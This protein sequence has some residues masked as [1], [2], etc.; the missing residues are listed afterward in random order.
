MLS[1]AT[2]S[3]DL[4]AA[5]VH[6]SGFFHTLIYLVDDKCCGRND[7]LRWVLHVQNGGLTILKHC[8]RAARDDLA[9]GP[10]EPAVFSKRLWSVHNALPVSGQLVAKTIT[11]R[12]QE[13]DAAWI[14]IKITTFSH[15]L[16]FQIEHFWMHRRKCGLILSSEAISVLHTSL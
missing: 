11:M 6:A 4:Q 3:K 16:D 10:L 2:A 1:Q 9:S 8:F 15:L 14:A 13:F 5:G 7:H 12:S